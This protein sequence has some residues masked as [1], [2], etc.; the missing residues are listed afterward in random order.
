MDTI[1]FDL[2]NLILNHLPITYSILLGYNDSQDHQFY[3]EVGCIHK[4]EKLA[5]RNKN[6]A[7][8]LWCFQKHYV[9][10]IDDSIALWNRII[11]KTLYRSK[12][13]DIHNE[14]NWYRYLKQL[15]ELQEKDLFCQHMNMSL[16]SDKLLLNFEDEDFII[17]KLSTEDLDLRYFIELAMTKRR[18]KVLEHLL[19]FYDGMLRI[20][21]LIVDRKNQ[22]IPNDGIANVSQCLVLA[23]VVKN[24]AVAD[25]LLR[26]RQQ[27]W[28]VIKP[29]VSYF[30]KF[31]DLKD[32]CGMFIDPSEEV[33][34]KGQKFIDIIGMYVQA[35][36]YV[37]RRS[38]TIKSSNVQCAL[39]DII[40]SSL[41]YHIRN[42]H[43]DIVRN[44]LLAYLDYYGQRPLKSLLIVYHQYFT[45][46]TPPIIDY[47]YKILCEKVRYL[48]QI[49]KQMSISGSYKM[50]KEELIKQLILTGY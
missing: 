7:W 26:R 27:S 24:L 21:S 42:S 22:Y 30:S 25:Y 23:F 1:P 16:H 38:H 50:P 19:P 3:L 37:D 39:E 33:D 18:Y 5:I 11:K 36:R 31:P 47:V 45:R 49:A 41:E 2:S 20:Q 9:R 35:N 46:T 14:Y 40:L 13:I 6:Y 15:S 4:K 17:S 12:I 48:K 43:V 8:L 10:Q 28:E 29:I 44:I 34:I 32:F